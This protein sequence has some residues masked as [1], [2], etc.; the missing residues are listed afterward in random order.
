MARNSNA[1]SHGGTR[2]VLLGLH[3]ANGERALIDELAASLARLQQNDGG[4]AQR[5]GFPSD[6]YATGETLYALHVA[7]GTPTSALAYQRGVSF[8]V[9]SQHEDGSWYVRSRSVKF[10]PYFE[11]GFP[12]GNDQWISTAGTS[13]AAIALTLAVRE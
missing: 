8:L 13:W 1:C 7:A 11:S 6:A 2:D 5:D 12:Y 9:N 10:Q 3:W 4:W